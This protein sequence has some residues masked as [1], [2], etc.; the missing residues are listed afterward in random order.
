MLLL[1]KRILPFIF[2]PYTLFFVFFLSV[3]KNGYLRH[4]PRPIH[5]HNWSSSI[6][7][8]PSSPLSSS[9]IKQKKKGLSTFYSGLACPWSESFCLLDVV[10]VSVVSMPW[11]LRAFFSLLLWTATVIVVAALPPHNC[12]VRWSLTKYPGWQR[13]T[14]KR[15]P[16]IWL[17]CSMCTF[18]QQ[19]QAPN[20][21]KMNEWMNNRHRIASHFLCRQR[22][23]REE[24]CMYHPC[25]FTNKYR[26]K[27]K[28][29][30]WKRV[31]K[32]VCLCVRKLLGPVRPQII[33]TIIINIIVVKHSSLSG[34][35]CVYVRTLRFFFV[36]IIVNGLLGLVLSLASKGLITY[37]LFTSS[38]KPQSFKKHWPFFCSLVAIATSKISRKTG[39]SK[40][41]RGHRYARVGM[42][43]GF[44]V[45][46]FDS[47]QQ[48]LICVS[49]FAGAQQRIK[50]A[51]GRL[52]DDAWPHHTEH[53][54]VDTPKK[55]S[56]RREYSDQ[57]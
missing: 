54:T 50:K 9:L 13:P 5:F 21:P 53:I 7:S 30:D 14:G 15:I 29:N 8:P 25:M 57:G 47:S 23:A 39:V 16:P 19:R 42:S 1:S 56:E 10:L 18:C 37:P 38:T 4:H 24:V 6:P 55:G 45:L 46:L 48:F 43:D 51:E 17:S 22:K 12:L 26:A 36:F 41:G 52:Q 2:L 31:N 40:I 28:G 20:K 35:A 44:V 11:P 32:S 3:H 34:R 27:K 33:I 49:R